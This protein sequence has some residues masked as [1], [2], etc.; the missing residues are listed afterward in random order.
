M[1]EPDDWLDLAVRANRVR[2][3]ALQPTPPRPIGA[4]GWHGLFS[5]AFMRSRNAMVLAD[6]QRT[7]VDV[8][9]AYAK[10]LHRRRSSLI[11]RPLWEFVHAGPL[12]TQEEWLELLR[13][14]EFAGDAV[15]ELPDGSTVK[16]HW[17]CHPEL[18]TGRRLVLFV[19]LGTSMAG[20]HVRRQVDEQSGNGNALSARELEIVRLIARGETGPEIAE[21]LHITHN[22]VR[23]HVNN[24][25]LKTGARSR[26]HLVAKALG[27]GIALG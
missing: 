16:V 15:M 19:A 23:T 6:A 1:N 22:T 26:A 24:A 17:G 2:D 3:L 21:Q 11:G 14:D 18:V 13:R 12:V 27:G 20:R 4:A 25:M 5:S 8:N 10:L 7:Q 9:A